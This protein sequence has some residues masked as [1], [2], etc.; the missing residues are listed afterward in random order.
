MARLVLSQ[1]KP[2]LQPVTRGPLP[3]FA[4]PGKSWE[5][6]KAYLLLI[7]VRRVVAC[8]DLA[9]VQARIQAAALPN[10]KAVRFVRNSS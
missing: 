9:V 7:L 8:A 5:K 6:V 4:V 1:G 2:R 10:Q 3:P